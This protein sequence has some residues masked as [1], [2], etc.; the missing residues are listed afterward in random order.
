[1]HILTFKI[2]V[3]QTMKPSEK[4]KNIFFS[5]LSLLSM[6]KFKMILYL[7]WL[8]DELLELRQINWYFEMK[9]RQILVGYFQCALRFCSFCHWFW[10]H[11]R[12]ITWKKVGD[13]NFS[14]DILIPYSTDPQVPM[15]FAIFKGFSTCLVKLSKHQIL[16]H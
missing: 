7:F 8:P 14:G 10:R 5:L 4:T 9:F 15:Q 1:M 3:T 13:Y 2:M 6:I 12:T 16:W 11:Y